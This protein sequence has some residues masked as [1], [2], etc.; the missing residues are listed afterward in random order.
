LSKR[1]EQ[2]EDKVKQNGPQNENLTLLHCT[3][4]ATVQP[5]VGPGRMEESDGHLSAIYTLNAVMFT[6]VSGK[7]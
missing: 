5:L 3:V 4:E 1:E 6:V 2:N 7:E